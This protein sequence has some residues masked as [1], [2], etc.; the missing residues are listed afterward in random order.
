M[1]EDRYF[2]IDGEWLIPAGLRPVTFDEAWAC[3]LEKWRILSVRGLVYEGAQSTCGWCRY[4]GGNCKLCPM[5]NRGY[6]LCHSTPYYQY[7]NS[8]TR[9]DRRYFATK[10]L[11]FLRAAKDGD[12][13][14]AGEI[15]EDSRNEFAR[16]T[17]EEH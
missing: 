6:A 16:L 2:E 10:E 3:T 1:A 13:E 8:R 7:V 9:D 5:G 14:K 12:W 4:A 15:A 11:Q 17:N